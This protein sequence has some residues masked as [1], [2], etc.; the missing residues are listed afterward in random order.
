MLRLSRL[1]DSKKCDSGVDMI[2]DSSQIPTQSY[3]SPSPQSPQSVPSST[4]ASPVPSIF[5]AKT[6]TRFPSSVSSLASSP[7][8]G[9]S[10]EGLGSSKVPLT[11]VKEDPLEREAGHTFTGDYFGISR[12]FNS[13]SSTA[14]NSIQASSTLE[15]H[16]YD[17]TDELPEG[18]RSPKNRR[19]DDSSFRGISRISSRLS[20]LSMKRKQKSVSD[21]SLD[22]VNELP[23]SPSG[24]VSS[25][26]VNP[27]VLSPSTCHSPNPPSPARTLFEERMN[28]S[29]IQP[30]D[31]NQANSVQEPEFIERH[32]TTPLLPPL[33]MDSPEN[34]DESIVN[35]PLQSPSVAD[36][37]D[38][39][40]RNSIIEN[41]QPL[42]WSSP[43][44]STR[45]S[46]S[47]MSRPR[48][49][50]R[51]TS[52]DAPPIVIADPDDEWSHKLGHANFTIHPEPYVPTVCD[53]E[54]LKQHRMDWDLARCNY[55]KHLVRTGEHS[56]VTSK[57]YQLTE[58]KWESVDSEWKRNHELV[59]S[60]LKES[61]G[62]ESLSLTKS[63]AH[64]CD[65]VKIPRLHDNDKFPEL[66]DQDIVGPMVVGPV[67]V[68]TNSQPKSFRKRTFL[69]FLRSIFFFRS[70][71]P[72]ATE[73]SRS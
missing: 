43:P 25:S 16:E 67:R 33:M 6:H 70:A 73:Q 30:I 12:R 53:V 40:N 11:E 42:N 13:H 4:P 37:T 68:R 39:S 58:E 9:N 2:M 10:T 34:G 21:S 24:S 18:A 38:D 1:M 52:A 64:P 29:G 32:A 63:N 19:S 71:S 8:T 17:L 49:G 51:T 15:S 50:T 56:G 61:G 27:T 54:T 57:I 28:D 60:S 36:V 35:S 59:I 47:S 65:M 41:A 48:A 66:G 5:S 23:C 26:W 69:K 44:L 20:S 7:V 31:I 22:Q 55:T 3:T 46:I 45:P 72:G 62:G 14:A